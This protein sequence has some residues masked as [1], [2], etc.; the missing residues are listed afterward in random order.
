MLYGRSGQGALLF[1]ACGVLSIWLA[2]NWRFFGSFQALWRNTL[3]GRCSKKFK[4]TGYVAPGFEAVREAFQENFRRADDLASQ[5]CVSWKGETVVD[6]VGYN[7][8]VEQEE[9][10]YNAE[11]LQV[12]FSVSKV[13]VAIVVA[14]L[15]DK[16][17]LSYD[18]PVCRYWP[19]FAKNGKGSITIK[20]VMRHES[21]LDHYSI[22]LPDELYFSDGKDPR[23]AKI[24]ESSPPEWSPDSKR[25]YN[26]YLYGITINEIVK[27]VDP[28]SRTIGEIL[29]DEICKNAKAEFYFGLPQELEPR[30]S[31]VV[32]EGPLG[33]LKSLLPLVTGTGPEFTKDMLRYTG[34]GTYSRKWQTQSIEY[35]EPSC[36]GPGGANARRYH[37]SHLPSQ[38]G[39]TNAR[40]L[41]KVLRWFNEG[42]IKPSTLERALRIST[43]ET[44]DAG[45]G[46]RST[47]SDGGFVYDLFPD[48]LLSGYYGWAGFGG[49]LAQINK[50]E[51]LVIAHVVKGL[52]LSVTGGRRLQS[53]WAATEACVIRAKDKRSLATEL[54]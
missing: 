3:L 29:Q 45:L 22:P 11:T 6:L 20:E 44:L 31:P 10:V 43:D 24:I 51:D 23:V 52:T 38:G 39:I 37:Q 48:T 26:G 35:K 17:L 13:V 25:C 4:V 14:T 12:P 19:E 7:L 49:S 21:G 15:V 33:I 16:G 41:S 42:G 5:Y 50:D 32:L 30:V 36:D 54:E 34:P 18:D 1:G 8:Q 28:D 40:S 9:R 27:R 46:L 47:I 53:I 2:R